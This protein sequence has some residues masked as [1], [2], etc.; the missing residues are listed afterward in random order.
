MA[1]AAPQQT[2]LLVPAREALEHG[3]RRQG[4]DDIQRSVA[5]D[6]SPATYERSIKLALEFNLVDLARELAAAGSNRYR[7]NATLKRWAHV[8]AP[9]V[10]QEHTG[11]TIPHHE[12]D[13]SV[14]WL[15]R[16][17]DEY[18]GKWVVLSGGELLAAGRG[19][20][21]RAIRRIRKA[22]PAPL[23]IHS[24]RE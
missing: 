16:H 23:F 13:R 9:P 14:E 3:Y 2:D 12:R 1:Q 17:A 6:P 24:I 21:R 15:Q 10:V 11:L 5:A 22:T 7:R 8:L 19:D 4:T 20:I 18:R